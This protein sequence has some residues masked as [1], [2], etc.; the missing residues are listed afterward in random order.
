MPCREVQLLVTVSA[1]AA[2]AAC[3]RGEPRTDLEG[4]VATITDESSAAHEQE[5]ARAAER[6]EPGSLR[7]LAPQEV[8][9]AISEA[10]Q[11]ILDAH[12]DEPLGYEVPFEV[13]GRRYV[14]RLERH[15]R[16]PNS[17]L[18]PTGEHVGVTVYLAQ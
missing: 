5:P 13:E 8:T 12:R 17:R 4:H 7:L 18:R 16:A 10:A 3:S 15:Y 9:A 1:A 2:V 6:D 11:E 14:A